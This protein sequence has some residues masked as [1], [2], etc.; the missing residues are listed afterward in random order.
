MT[1]EDEA[2]TLS[3][4]ERSRRSRK[5]ARGDHSE[6]DATKCLWLRSHR[7]A[8]EAP[9]AAHGDLPEPPVPLADDG[10]RLWWAVVGQYELS[11]TEMEL[12]GQACVLL[13]YIM[14]ADSKLAAGGWTVA[15]RY[16]QEAASPLVKLQIEWRRQFAALIAQL[17]LPDPASGA[18]ELPS[19]VARL[20]R[21]DRFSARVDADGP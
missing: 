13:D 9:F 20:P 8:A 21:T 1:R 10:D 3:S 15:G 17:R 11:A 12:L 7:G 2:V 5:H 6:C 18:V 14:L 4:T 16:H 19:S